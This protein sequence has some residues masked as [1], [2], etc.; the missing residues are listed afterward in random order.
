MNR[1][2]PPSESKGG[3]A[4]LTFNSEFR[5]AARLAAIIV[6]V[7]LNAAL[8]LVHEPWRDEGQ[9]WLLVG[10]LD[11][12]SLFSQMKIE[13]HPALWYLLLL[14]F[15]KLG[16]PVI[17]ER[18]ISLTAVSIAAWLMLFRSPFPLP[19]STVVLLSPL[20]L[21][22]LPVIA[23]SYAIGL[24][25]ILL[26]AVYYDKRCTSPIIF[27]VMIALLF[28]THVIFAGIGIALTIIMLVDA[29]QAMDSCS[30]FRIIMGIVIA[31][32]GCLATYIE[33]R[34]GPKSDITLAVVLAQIIDDPMGVLL[35]TFNMYCDNICAYCSW[36]WGKVIL[37]V[38]SL[39]GVFL[40]VILKPK[41]LWRGCLLAVMGIGVQLAISLFVY[42]SGGQRSIYFWVVIM[43]ASWIYLSDLRS[44]NEVVSAKHSIVNLVPSSRKKAAI[45]SSVTI[46]TLAI[47]CI[48]TY[49]K[50]WSD[51][52]NDV[53]GLYSGG[54]QMAYYIQENIASDAVVVSVC[55][56]MAA[57]IIP[58]CENSTHFWS[59]SAQ[60][61]FTYCDWSS[62]WAIG[63]DIN[64]VVSRYSQAFPEKKTMYL[65][66]NTG[67]AVPTGNF[68]SDIMF[69]Q[70]GCLVSDEN[71]CLYELHLNS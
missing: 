25:L 51:A 41:I 36:G 67:Y 65:L 40:P 34:G 26:I 27:G 61:Y 11:L 46:V 49:P 62:E 69:S 12:P 13:G 32:A 59:A 45:A 39:L 63:L 70:S 48:C 57:S 19:L 38:V 29:T 15:A 30:R 43:L 55:D 16:L 18:V 1:F 35:K 31:L 66:A 47:F 6:F 60:N 5:N 17:A 56:P 20:Y 50:T 68:S 10:S 9:A 71:F 23:R 37:P 8:V 21:Y 4:A 54:T 2:K 53:T 28:Q 44:A 7:L 33:L 42:V 52:Y 58:F 64:D 14:P 22:Y 3:K 24:L